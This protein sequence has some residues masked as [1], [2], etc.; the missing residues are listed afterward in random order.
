[1]GR[2]RRPIAALLL[3]GAATLTV[4]SVTSPLPPGVTVAVSAADLPAGH[5]VTPGDVREVVLPT[6]AVPGGSL[7]AGGLTGQRLSGPVRAGEPFTDRRIVTEAPAAALDFGRVAMP[8]DVQAGAL[9]WLTPGVRVSL[10]AFRTD[11]VDLGG[12]TGDGPPPAHVVA[13]D[14]VVLDV[15]PRDDEGL[16]ATADRDGTRTV[17]VSVRSEEAAR[18]AAAGGGWSLSPVVLP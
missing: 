16:L 15:P 12:S 18:L 8:L 4:E 17:L 3:A 1:M 6:D 14:V 10:L 7:P 11:L 5:L 9:R 13:R 2:H